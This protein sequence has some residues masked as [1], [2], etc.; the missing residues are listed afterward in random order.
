MKPVKVEWVDS[1]HAPGWRDPDD[2]DNQPAP[3]VTY[4]VIVKRSRQAVTV[5]QSTGE[6]HCSEAMT[7]PR[8]VIRKI[9]PLREA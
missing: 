7:I 2:Y 6:K 4:G 3:C 9:T 1:C 8:S 5:V